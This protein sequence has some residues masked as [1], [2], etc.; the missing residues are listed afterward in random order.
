[1]IGHTWWEWPLVG[2]LVGFGWTLGC[3]LASALLSIL[4]G[5]RAKPAP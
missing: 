5:V 4:G 2:A 3:A 1:M